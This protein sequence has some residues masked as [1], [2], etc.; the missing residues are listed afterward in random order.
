MSLHDYFTF[1]IIM[2]IF[3]SIKMNEKLMCNRIMKHQFVY[4]HMFFKKEKKIL[5]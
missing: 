4:I 3:V 5:I 2:C 1:I